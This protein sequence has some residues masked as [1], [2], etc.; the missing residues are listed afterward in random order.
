MRNA[1]AAVAITME[2]H[3]MISMPTWFPFSIGTFM[4]ARV[5]LAALYWTLGVA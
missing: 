3:D 2:T 4:M 1:T 5:K